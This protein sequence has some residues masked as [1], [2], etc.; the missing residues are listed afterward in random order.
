MARVDNSSV[1]KKDTIASVRRLGCYNANGSA[2]A[3]E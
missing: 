1:E 3:E 2:R